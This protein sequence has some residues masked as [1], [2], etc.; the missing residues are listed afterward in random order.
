MRLRLRSEEGVTIVVAIML[1]TLMLMIG[2]AS[3]AY[4][5]VQQRQSSVER[6]GESAFNLTEGALNT[7]AFILS[8]RWPGLTPQPQCTNA[9]G[10]AGCPDNARLMASFT[11]PDYA[12]GSSWS[13]TVRDDGTTPQEF[14]DAA[15]VNLQPNYDANAN[16]RL[17]VR[18]EGIVAGRRRTLAA[19]VQIE[20]RSEE[21]PRK[22]II[23]GRFSTSN[24]GNKTI[25]E[26][27]STATSPHEVLLRCADVTVPTCA[28]YRNDGSR[29]QV[30]GTVL[31]GQFVGKPALD[32]A[33]VERLK[34]R[35][36]ADGTYFP[37]GQCPSGLAGAVIF[38]ENANCSYTGNATIN[39][40]AAPGVV[41]FRDGKLSLGGTTNFHGVIY[42]LNQADSAEDLVT[43]GGN[44]RVDGG[45]FVDG[46]GGIAVGSSG[47]NLVYTD[48]AFSSVTSYGTASV[49]QNS[50]RE[51]ASP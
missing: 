35:A 4:V 11:G 22:T 49:V 26:T 9:G 15:A 8:R 42:M 23:A 50:F 17:W 14:Y 32:P 31:G 21:F 25:V 6:L 13:T 16:K 27:N 44:T 48:S 3:Y 47:L 45:I 29:P 39:S 36:E 1:M 34:A 20:T 46:Q 5:D 43:L 24:N 38:V 19:L 40:A 41:I 28:K 2:L 10:G 51:V 12:S 7:Q 18:S 37:A 33:T 30:N